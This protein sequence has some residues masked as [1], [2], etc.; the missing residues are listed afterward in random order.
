VSHL[1]HL[2][3]TAYQDDGSGENPLVDDDGIPRGGWDGLVAVEQHDGAPLS[4]TAK[5]KVEDPPGR[6]LPEDSCMA[7]DPAVTT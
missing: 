5:W 4:T 7:L 3:R 1:V 6:E 2:E